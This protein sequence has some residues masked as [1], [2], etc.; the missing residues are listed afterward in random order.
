MNHKFENGRR[1]HS[2][3]SG[4]YLFPNDE[5]EADRLDIHHHIC[6]MQLDGELN[7]APLPSDFSGRV[8]DL[9]TGT[10]IWAS[11]MGDKYPSA[12]I[13]GVDLS[14][15]ESSCVRFEVDDIE[16]QW[17]YGRP[18]NFIHARWLAG[19]IRDWPKLMR[20]T[21]DNLAP[22]GWAEFKDWDV[23]PR[24]ANGSFDLPDNSIKKWH[25]L[26]VGT[27]ESLAGTATGITS[28]G[29]EMRKRFE[30]AGFANIQERVFILPVGGWPQDEKLK[31]IGKYY[32]FA[33]REGLEALS[34]RILTTFLNWKPEEVKVLNAKFREEMKTT[35]FYHKY[36]MVCGQKA[37]S[38]S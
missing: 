35:Q 1:Y 13:L 27:C 38:A 26:V 15:P 34:L 7:I 11:D 18:F 33:L 25:D 2:Y 14:P 3:K 16:E 30:D 6:L 20:Q 9:G 12:E 28:P 5:P 17:T 4:Q 21:Y 32:F 19:A 23:R 29:I 31:E 22:G 8:L 36:H 24:L 37:S 10:G